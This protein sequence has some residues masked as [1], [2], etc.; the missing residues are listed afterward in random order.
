MTRISHD[1]DLWQERAD[2]LGALLRDLAQLR[3][4]ATVTYAEAFLAGDKGT[5]RQRE[6]AAKLAA[7]PDHLA[8]EEAAAAVAAYQLMIAVWQADLASPDVL[9]GEVPVD[10]A[11]VESLV[12]LGR[13]LAGEE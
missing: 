3:S 10:G 13:I 7:A 1:P 2:H 12:R 5:D 8:A 9:S 11:A 4:N 6:Q